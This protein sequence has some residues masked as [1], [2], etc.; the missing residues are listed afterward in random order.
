MSMRI[1]ASTSRQNYLVEVITR[2]EFLALRPDQ[3]NINNSV[4]YIFDEE[5][6]SKGLTSVT[7][8][9]GVIWIGSLAFDNNRLTSVTIPDSVI[10]VGYKAFDHNNITR[11]NIGANVILGGLVINGKSAFENSYQRNE[12]RAGI[13]TLSWQYGYDEMWGGYNPR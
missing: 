12:R 8:P 13:Y 2:T 9:D 4:L 10:Y 3:K 7:I 5:F 1:T 6:K 11:V